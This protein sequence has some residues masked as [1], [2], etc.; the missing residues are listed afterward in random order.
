MLATRF[1][2]G[3]F[4]SGLIPGCVYVCSLY[5]PAAHL[6]WRMSMLM[7]SNIASNV[8]SNILAYAIAHIHNSNGYHG[9][10]W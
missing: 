8:V 3:I 7:V 9:W 10:R 6:Q 4:D 1:V 5:Y 2:V